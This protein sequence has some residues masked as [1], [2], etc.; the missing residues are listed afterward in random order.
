MTVLI[1]IGVNLAHYHSD[2]TRTVFFGEPPPIM[3]EI[4]SIVKTAQEDAVAYCRAGVLIGELDQ[5]ARGYIAGL[6]YGDHFGH[7]LGHGIGLEVH[8]L[9]ILRNK[10]PYKEVPL[11][12]GMVITIEP[13]IYLPE[14]GGVRIED[15]IVITEEG[16]INLTNRSTDLFI[17]E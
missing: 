6:G 14:I 7:G 1:D 12:A 13:G 3:R 2:M 9:P 16:S 8:E 5:F 10:T 15:T 11:S 17:L 4:Y